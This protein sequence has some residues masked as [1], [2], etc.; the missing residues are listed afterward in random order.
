MSGDGDYR[1]FTESLPI[2]FPFLPSS[3]FMAITF[4]VCLP[5]SWEVAFLD[6]VDVRTT[7]RLELVHEKWQRGHSG[8]GSRGLHSGSHPKP[9]PGLAV[10]MVLL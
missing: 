2:T 8:M 10:A 5:D 3:H 7:A 4:R 9:L 6:W 1:E